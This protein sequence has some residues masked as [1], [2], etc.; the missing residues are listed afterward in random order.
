MRWLDTLLGRL[1]RSSLLA[2]VADEIAAA[3]LEPVCCRVQAHAASMSAAEARGYI[4]ARA[5]AVVDP[6]VETAIAGRQ[7]LRGSDRESLIQLVTQRLIRDV[8][9]RIPG[10]TRRRRAA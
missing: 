9:G 10:P 2:Q 8:V 7:Q 6:G 4:R 3:C 5:A 1:H